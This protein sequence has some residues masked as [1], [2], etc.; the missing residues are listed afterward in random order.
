MPD[1]APDGVE[2]ERKWKT[3]KVT[4]TPAA[5][6]RSAYEL[7]TPEKGEDAWDRVA[8][9]VDELG[10]AIVN[11]DE[12]GADRDRLSAALRKMARRT[13]FQRRL[14]RRAVRRSH[15]HLRSYEALLRSLGSAVGVHVGHPGQRRYPEFVERICA[16]ALKAR[17]DNAELRA[18]LA[19][20]RPD[21]ETAPSLRTV[22]L[23][24]ARRMAANISEENVARRSAHPDELVR[25]AEE[26]GLT[27]V[28]D[29][30]EACAEPVDTQP[31]VHR[32]WPCPVC[33]GSPDDVCSC[34]RI[35][36]EAAPALGLLDPHGAPAQTWTHPRDEQCVH[37]ASVDRLASTDPVID[38][39]REE[40]SRPRPYVAVW[41][42]DV[43]VGEDEA[44]PATI[45]K[46][47]WQARDSRVLDAHGDELFLVHGVA[48]WE[49][50]K[51]ARWLVSVV[52][53]APTSPVI[54][55]LT[56]ENAGE[57]FDIAAIERAAKAAFKAALNT[58]TDT[59]WDRC[60][61]VQIAHW[62]GVV[63]AVLASL[64]GES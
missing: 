27:S 7:T 40:C 46:R 17:A 55:V 47:P 62:S 26:H 42:P 45:P 6:L 57:N 10:Y 59:D 23:A 8:R 12:Q 1:T 24:E 49:Q 60:G 44:R 15:E 51:V 33:G 63:R 41:G 34:E 13:V 20:Q 5:I 38:C 64:G 18:Q 54:N 9:G 14:A 37:C 56:S 58:K 11:P 19:A 31:K 16:A 35:S 50:D 28:A 36:H 30:Y 3:I 2:T 52:N 39:P 61:P 4:I 21:G 53:A 32:N 29:V 48:R 25:H 43:D 22:S